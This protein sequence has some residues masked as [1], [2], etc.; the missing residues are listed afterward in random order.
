M[1][2]S[3]NTFEVG[4]TVHVAP[5][6]LLMQRN[7]REATPCPALVK[8]IK[9]VG[10]LQP[11]TAVITDDGKLR[12]PLGRRNARTPPRCGGSSTARAQPGRARTFDVPHRP[13]R[14]PA[15]LI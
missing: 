10:V 4:T 7:V 15:C 12:V 5:T 2:T 3:T 11:I 6:D 1:T 8:S 14:D 13:V 9:D